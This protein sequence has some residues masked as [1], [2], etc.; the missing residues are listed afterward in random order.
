MPVT[1]AATGHRPPKLGGYSPE[2]AGKLQSIARAYLSANHPDQIISG[3]ALGWDTA[4]ALAGLDLGIPLIA[5]VPFPGQSSRWPTMDFLVY[6][7]I[8]KRADRVQIIYQSYNPQ[9][10]QA[11]NQ[12][13]VNS[14]NQLVAMW[15]G[16]SGGTANC[17]QYAKKVKKPWVNLYNSYKESL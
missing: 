9:A 17:I 16:S 3:M 15:D 1:F 14:C 5:A 10:F 8:M 13:M 12:Y 6:H 7:Q 2:A 11:R 4:W